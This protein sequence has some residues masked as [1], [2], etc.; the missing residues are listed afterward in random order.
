MLNILSIWARLALSVLLWIV[1]LPVMLVLLP[2][3]TGRS[4]SLPALRPVPVPAQTVAIDTRST[5]G[6]Y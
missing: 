6:A 1:L 5:S 4:A 2:F 3:R